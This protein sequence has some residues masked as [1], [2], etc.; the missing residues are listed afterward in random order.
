MAIRKEVKV[1]AIVLSGIIVLYFGINFLKGKDFFS[2]EK[3]GAL[4]RRRVESGIRRTEVLPH[5]M[6][7]G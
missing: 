2:N 1:G 3:R 7:A 6:E 5:D 4:R